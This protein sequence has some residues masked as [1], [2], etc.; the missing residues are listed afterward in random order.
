MVDLQ[1]APWAFN[2]MQGT[3]IVDASHD[4]DTTDLHKC[5]VYISDFFDLQISNLCIV[6]VGAL[7]GHEIGNINVLY[8]FSTIRIIL[9]NDDCLIQLLPR[10]HHHEI[11]IK[12]SI[13]G[14]HCG[15]VPVGMPS[16]N[17]TTTGG[18]QWDLNNTKMEFGGLI[19][20][21]NIAKGQIVTVHSDTD[22]IWTISIRKT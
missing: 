15:L 17:T 8:R 1:N 3:K 9:L 2:Q 14:P 19:S 22:L 10:S 20:T 12:P 4:Q 7:G 13:L 18:L 6:V 16:T 21:S 5:V 11:H